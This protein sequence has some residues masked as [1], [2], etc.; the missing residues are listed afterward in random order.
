MAKKNHINYIVDNSVDNVIVEVIY[1]SEYYDLSYASYSDH[2]EMV[3]N[4][5]TK[6]QD[7]KGYELF[8]KLFYYYVT[9]TEQKLRYS[10]TDVNFPDI[11]IRANEENMKK[12]THNL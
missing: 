7:G 8:S 6:I 4:Y 2:G 11:T 12:I 10:Y 1:P 5:Q 3:I 9:K